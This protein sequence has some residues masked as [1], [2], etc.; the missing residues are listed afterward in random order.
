MAGI[1]PT[2]VVLKI[3]ASDDNI[4]RFRV[5][6]LEFQAAAEVFQQAVGTGFTALVEQAGQHVPLT[7]ESWRAAAATAV[8]AKNRA[9]APPVVRIYASQAAEPVPEPEVEADAV[10]VPGPPPPPEPSAP[11][12]EP[13][14]PPLEPPAPP[15]GASAPPPEASV[16]GTDRASAGAPGSGPGGLPAGLSAGLPGAAAALA[17]L[18]R[19]P[20]RCGA[21]RPQPYEDLAAG[22]H[23]WQQ[24][25]QAAQQSHERA[26]RAQ[27]QQVQQAV[28]AHVAQA[29][30][31][32]QQAVQAAQEHARAA[33]AAAAARA[34]AAQ[35]H[36][37]AA[38]G[39]A[40]QG[41]S[42]P[43]DV[44]CVWCSPLELRS[45]RRRVVGCSITGPVTLVDSEVFVDGGVI[46]GP[47]ELRGV[48]R[49]VLSNAAIIGPVT[50]SA[51]SVFERC[52]GGH[53][54]GPVSQSW[55]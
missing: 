21:P 13:A 53:V 28:A 1:P 38:R 14:A 43:T 22:L 6:S 41:G 19:P 29:A 47:V 17:Q 45:Q 27:V 4:L 24:N 8:G 2:E 50:Y 31:A 51:G 40:A 25:F 10:P 34:Q 36:A 33:S 44:G 18:F 46:T 11:P 42:I 3:H 52:N 54:V 7:A 9:G 16:G 15:L 55:H 49:L 26:M 39:A 5:P 12:L 48:S 30:Q 32:A 35:E 20:P 23:S 37:R